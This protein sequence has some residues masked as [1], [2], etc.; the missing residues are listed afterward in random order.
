[1]ER[2]RAVEIELRKAKPPGGGLRTRNN[3]QPDENRGNVVSH[4]V[5]DILQ[6]NAN[7]QLGI[8]ELKEMLDRSNEEVERLRHVMDQPEPPTSPSGTPTP[9]LGAELSAKELHVHHHYHAPATSAATTPKAPRSQVSRR[10]R[11]KRASVASGSSS[12]YTTP[13]SSVSV[14]HSPARGSTASA[15][16]SQTSVTI[17]HARNQRWSMQSN[18][19]GFTNS[20]SLPSSPYTDSVFDRVFSDMGTELSRPT[21][22]ESSGA[23]S[24]LATGSSGLPGHQRND[25]IP[26]LSLDGTMRTASEGT[27]SVSQQLS[28]AVRNNGKGKSKRESFTPD[29]DAW[30]AGH[31]TILEENEDLDFNQQEP[32]QGSSDENTE[33]SLYKPFAPKM[34]RA[35]SHE[36]LLSVSGMDIH[37]LRSRPSQLL[38]GHRLLSS[39]PSSASLSSQAVLSGAS[40]TAIRPALSRVE[41]DSRSYLSNLAASQRKPL[42]KKSS[43]GNLGQKVGG[44]VR[45]RWGYAAA[46]PPSPTQTPTPTLTTDTASIDSVPKSIKSASSIISANGALAQSPRKPTMLLRS[47]GINQPGPIFGFAPEPKLPKRVITTGVDEEALRECLEN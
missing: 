25:S 23:L 44:W 45:G 1:M 19:T 12:G 22:P 8:V 11:K 3:I 9:T 2:R 34:R 17:P 13:R 26:R 16:L 28:S 42:A 7:L 43:V 38:V 14:I 37:T 5:K 29:F 40:A 21:S 20:S 27:V 47:P 30:Q 24:P 4:F 36:S 6:D 31:S 46:A 18:Q 41:N 10:S 32:T 35:A 33:F 15:I 39:S